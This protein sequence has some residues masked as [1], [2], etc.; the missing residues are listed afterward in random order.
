MSSSLTVSAN[1]LCVVSLMVECNIANIIARV[2]FPYPA[3]IF[4]AVAEWLERNPHKIEYVS[5][6]LT[7]VTK[8][9]HCRWN[10]AVSTKHGYVGSNPT[11]GTSYTLIV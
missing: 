3:P 4:H 1:F 10:G 7:S 2:R 9:Y 6:N 5:S 8:L 11:S